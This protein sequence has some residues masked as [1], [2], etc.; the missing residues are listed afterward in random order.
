MLGRPVAVK[1]LHPDLAADQSF[2]ERFRREAIS[3]A[4]LAHP[5]VV[6]TFDTGLDEGWPSS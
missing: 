4:R 3:A 6:G 2:R 5:N 1:L